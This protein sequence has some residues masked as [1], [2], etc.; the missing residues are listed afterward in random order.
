MHATRLPCCWQKG[1][2]RNAV[3]TLIRT[4]V[5]VAL[6]QQPAENLRHHALVSLFGRSD[7]DIVLNV[8]GL[9][10]ALELGSYLVDELL[11]RDAA[12]L[13]D[14]MHFGGVL[15]RACQEV[16]RAPAPFWN[17]AQASATIVVSAVPIC[18]VLLT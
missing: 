5:D 6:L 15:V 14:A 7:K 17:R 9:P 16:D 1:L 12:L 4:Q 18:G 13:G 10:G 8:Q 2:A 3:P 11:R